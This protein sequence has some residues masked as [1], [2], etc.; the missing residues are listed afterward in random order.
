[1]MVRA[2]PHPCRCLLPELADIRRNAFES[3]EYDP[4]P[5]RMLDDID[6]AKPALKNM[7]D[8]VGAGN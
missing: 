5:G 7:E 2:E 1:M 4:V 8:T 6:N 3:L